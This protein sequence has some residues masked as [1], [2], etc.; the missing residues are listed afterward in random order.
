METLT[1][2]MEDKAMDYIEK[3]DDMGGVYEAIERGFFQKEIADSAYKYQRE[4]DAKE[5]I[6]VGVNEY[7]I[8]EPECPIELLRID[9]KVE[10]QQITNLQKLR[11]ERNND[12][13]KQ[14]LSKLHDSADK[15][16]NLM[17]TIIEAVKAYATLGEICGVL[18]TV[19][20]EY[21]ELIVV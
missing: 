12:K 4:I 3:I 17:P 16:E 21:K 8:E 20:G 1:N 13:V 11:R 6:L 2:Q 19:Y 10:E 7:Y 18:R 5:R 14:V 9:P 15:N